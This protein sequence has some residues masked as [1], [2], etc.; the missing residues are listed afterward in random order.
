MST[1]DKY[2][3]LARLT[4]ISPELA[5]AARESFA[6]GRTIDQ[7]KTAI[8]SAMAVSEE[9]RAA[10]EKFW[11]SAKVGIKPSE[12]GNLL[13]GEFEC[14]PMAGWISAATPVAPE[15]RGLTLGINWYVDE[16][17]IGSKSFAFTIQYDDPDTDDEGDAT[18]MKTIRRED[19]TKGLQIMAEN[20]PDHWADFTHEDGAHA[21]AITYDVA[22]Q[23]IVLGSVVYG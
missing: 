8:R 2:T 21:D 1:T 10:P 15:G 14:N 4:D 9:E 16:N 20:Y 13:C 6:A 7:V 18:G 19:I 11:V 5:E 12:I 17:F 23:C 22:M 3:F